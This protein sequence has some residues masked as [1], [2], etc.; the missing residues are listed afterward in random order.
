MIIAAATAVALMIALWIIVRPFASP[1]EFYAKE[2]NCSIDGIDIEILDHEHEAAFRD[3]WTF[4]R[5]HVS[6]DL[7]DTIFDPDNMEND[8][9][10]T[11]RFMLRCALEK[12]EVKHNNPDISA[13]GHYR[14][15]VID[16]P[17]SLSVKLY[18]IQ[19]NAEGEYL[20]IYGGI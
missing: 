3:P 12:N 7:K 14:P 11:A 5:V 16:H 20:E 8:L 17:K 6:G 1:L 4:Y 9:N 13:E 2:F 15:R 19:T 10:D 18:I